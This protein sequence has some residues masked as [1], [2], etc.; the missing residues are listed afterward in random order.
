MTHE[1]SRAENDKDTRALESSYLARGQA[2]RVAELSAAVAALGAMPIRSY[3]ESR[4]LALSA[5]VQ[6]E[7]ERCSGWYFV[8][9]AGGG[10]RLEHAGAQVAVLT[11]AS[12]LGRAILGRCV[13]EC[14]E[15]NTPAGSVELEILRAL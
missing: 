15:F 3:D 10:A 11:P 2:R 5:L 14:I 9:S 13:G 12:P 1:E 7:G 4:P 6:L 8:A